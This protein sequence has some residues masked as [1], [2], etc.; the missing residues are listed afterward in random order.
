MPFAY[1]SSQVPL[2]PSSEKISVALRTLRNIFD[3]EK[4]NDSHFEFVRLV[5][6]TD[7]YSQ[8]RKC[9]K[10]IES[11]T[12]RVIVHIGIGGSVLG[13]RAVVGAMEGDWKTE[14]ELYILDTIDDISITRVC[15][16]IRGCSSADEFAVVVA[17]KS[18]NT[19]EVLSNFMAVISEL[20]KHKGYAKRVVVVSDADS[21][22][23]A[24]AKPI[25]YHVLS[26]PSN[27]GG[28]FSMFTAANL[29]PLALLGV[30]VE[31][32]VH[33]ARSVSRHLGEENDPTLLFCEDIDRCVRAGSR[34]LDFFFFDR[35]LELLGKWSRQLWGE[36]L[37]K[38]KDKDGYPIHTWLLPT[39]SI[40][41]EDLHS[42]LQ[43]YFGGPRDRVTLFVPPSLSEGR[44]LVTHPF[45]ELIQGLQ[46]KRTPD[47]TRIIYESVLESYKEHR[48]TSAEVSATESR[49]EFVGAFMQW[50]MCA[51][52]ALGEAWNIN[53][54]DQPEVEGYKSAVR[55]KLANQN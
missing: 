52:A 17:S 38:S 16:A 32:L 37:G 13:V 21:K 18:G 29:L 40:G 25:G 30:P 3:A 11:K 15:E 9:A 49:A 12:L 4:I 1:K 35:R 47:I 41:T 53:V 28:R 7:A 5:K 20:E 22:L 33:G 46:K 39:V 51:I 45:S 54:F 26:I 50:Q 6:T 27:I 48:L 8:V 31:E 34:T 23:A 2:G 42:M 24:I 36:S 19:T 44:V 14:R 55:D 43:F 10:R